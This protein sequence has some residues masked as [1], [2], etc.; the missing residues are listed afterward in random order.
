MFDYKIVVPDAVFQKIMWWINKSEHEVS[1]FGSLDFD[2][3]S[4]VFLVRDAILMKQEVGPT[5]TEIDPVAIGKAM[6]EMRAEPNALKWHWHSHVNMDVFWSSDDRALIKNLGEKGWICAT[7][8]NKRREMKS[9]FYTMMEVKAMEQTRMKEL[10]IDDIPTT[11]QRLLPAELWQA[12][13]KSYEEHVKPI[14]AKSYPHSNFHNRRE[15]VPKKGFI[16][17]A[18]R[19][20]E[21]LKNFK[22]YDH[23]DDGFRYSYLHDRFLY[24][25][26]Y[27]KS[28]KNEDDIIM[29]IQT[30]DHEEVD[31]AKRFYENRNGEFEKLY[32][33]ALADY[34]A[35]LGGP[36]EDENKVIELPGMN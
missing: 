28:L 18:K 35:G 11:I 8:F 3:T 34:T 27:D 23:D 20:V 13:D 36:E 4:G 7:V 12:W 9:A 1:G 31:A 15:E 30:M 26:M 2:E 22:Q 25:P 14:V 16:D 33:K 29:M 24:N 10:F 21:H 5:S 6:Y 17:K 32:D 19:N